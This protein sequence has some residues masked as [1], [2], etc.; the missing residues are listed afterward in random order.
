MY[1][2]RIEANKIKQNKKKKESRLF[3]KQ[4]KRDFILG[5]LHFQF[6]DNRIKF[7]ETISAPIHLY[8]FP[9]MAHKAN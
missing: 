5:S 9:I 8:Q 2:S 3:Q 7:I 1:H 6:I 4:S